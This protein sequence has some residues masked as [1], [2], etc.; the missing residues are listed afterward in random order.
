MIDDIQNK[1]LT[2][3]VSSLIL[4]LLSAWFRIRDRADVYDFVQFIAP[5]V[6]SD[7]HWLSMH[8]TSYSELV[9]CVLSSEPQIS[10]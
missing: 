4:A 6:R 7:A 2:F 8:G 9:L 3:T 5:S 10:A 1:Y